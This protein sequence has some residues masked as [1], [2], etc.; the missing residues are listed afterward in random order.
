[1]LQIILQRIEMILLSVYNNSSSFRIRCSDGFG[2]LSD[3]VYV[4]C[5]MSHN[6]VDNRFDTRTIYGRRCVRSSN[7]DDGVVEDDDGIIDVVSSVLITLIINGNNKSISLF[8]SFFSRCSPTSPLSDFFFLV[9][10]TTIT[11]AQPSTGAGLEVTSPYFLLWYE[12][13][14]RRMLDLTNKAAVADHFDDAASTT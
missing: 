6:D 12:T 9:P 5:A 2:S 11:T 4:D 10:K 14:A 1:M 8:S 13:F 3:D 7:D